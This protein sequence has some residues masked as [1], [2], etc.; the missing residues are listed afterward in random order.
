MLMGRGIPFGFRISDA[1]L[2]WFG[3]SAW[4][5]FM[6]LSLADTL[7]V[8]FITNPLIQPA[9]VHCDT[10]DITQLPPPLSCSVDR[11]NRFFQEPSKPAFRRKQNLINPTCQ[12]RLSNPD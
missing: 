5:V 9:A 12:S 3:V 10:I 1:A 2:C 8:G 11:P 6:L 4:H 7:S